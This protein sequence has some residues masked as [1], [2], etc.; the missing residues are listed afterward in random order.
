M[1]RIAADGETPPG[2]STLPWRRRLRL[3]AFVGGGITKLDDMGGAVDFGVSVHLGLV[4]TLSV[5]GFAAASFQVTDEWHEYSFEHDSGVDCSLAGNRQRR[6]Y[7]LGGSL[8]LTPGHQ[9]VFLG[10][11][12]LNQEVEQYSDALVEI[13]APGSTVN[14]R[15]RVDSIRRRVLHG[16]L[17]AE[18]GVQLG[19]RR[20]FELRG[21][22]R[23][24]S[25]ALDAGVT[26]GLPIWVSR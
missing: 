8:R 25:G 17:L 23:Y 4:P 9:P 13:R 16:Q 18:L 12:T 3:Q 6:V 5:Q 11:G 26:V 2:P 10:L 7:M 21:Y 22:A 14:A 24:R 1:D 20:R 19:P 15:D